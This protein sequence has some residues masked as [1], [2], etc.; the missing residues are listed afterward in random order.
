M[1]SCHS[2]NSKMKMERLWFYNLLDLSASHSRTGLFLLQYFAVVDVGSKYIIYLWFIS[3][4][5]M[6]DNL[7]LSTCVSLQSVLCCRGIHLFY[8]SGDTYIPKTAFQEK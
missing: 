8:A 1:R 6:V 2:P 7:L 4:S 5:F 3:L